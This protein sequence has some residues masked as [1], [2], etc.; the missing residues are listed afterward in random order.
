MEQAVQ[1]VENMCNLLIR[2]RLLQAPDVQ[3]M[4]RRWRL[5]A[6]EA[7]NDVSKFAKWLVNNQYLTGFQA[8]SLARGHA[9]HFFLGQYKLLDRIGKGRMAGVYKGLHNLGNIVAVKILP[10]SK[11]RDPQALARFQREAKMAVKLKHANVVRAFH[12]GNASGVY[13]LVMELLEGETL[14]DVLKRRHKFPV[15]EAVGIV[16]QA[17]LGL[18]HIHEQGLIHRD[19]KPANLMLVPPNPPGTPDTTLSATVKIL[20]IGLGRALF[21]ENAPPDMDD[22]QLTTEG[23]VLGTPDYLAPEQARDAH[24][25]DVRADIYSL[26][27]LLFHVLTGQVPFPDKNALHQ[28]VRHATETPRALRDLEPS[29]PEALQGVVLRMM[30]KSADHRFATPGQAA[31]ALQPFLPREVAAPAEA[32]PQQQ[33]YL[34]WLESEGARD[35]GTPGEIPTAVAGQV[36]LVAVSPAT[37]HTSTRREFFLLF[38]GFWV[39][40]AT[41]LV[42]ETILYFGLRP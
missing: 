11:V 9:D 18:Q 6:R 5:E 4:H 41:V 8:E 12:M 24:K 32:G 31:A 30:A 36:E 42:V 33:A 40:V 28:I 22:M 13:F 29:V 35:G 21:D 26:G 14:E 20:D 16:H 27:C 23:A 15:G 39:G 25:V 2:S 19:L 37:P 34:K 10:P 7:S 17:L 1:S 38:V 3:L